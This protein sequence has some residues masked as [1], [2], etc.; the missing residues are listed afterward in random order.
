VAETGETPAEIPTFHVFASEWWKRN[1]A[2]LAE[3]TQL[4]YRWRLDHLL[5]FFHC[6]TLDAINVDAVDGYISAKLAEGLS[7]RSVNM[8]LILLAA[9]LESAVERE[10][11]DRNRAKR[12]AGE[13]TQAA[14]LLSRERRPDRSATRRS[15]QARP[16]H[17]WPAGR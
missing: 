14:A 5:P 7:P 16:R 10:L 12:Q 17:M 3:N 8:T 2:S 4:D 13:G 6:Y 15:W 11:I 9:I 1:E